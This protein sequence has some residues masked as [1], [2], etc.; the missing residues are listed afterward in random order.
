MIFWKRSSFIDSVRHSAGCN[1]FLL[2]KSPPD[3][4]FQRVSAI[5]G[6]RHFFHTVHS[7]WPSAGNTQEMKWFWKIPAA[8]RPRHEVTETKWEISKSAASDF[9]CLVPLPVQEGKNEAGEDTDLLCSNRNQMSLCPQAQLSSWNRSRA[10]DAGRQDRSIEAA[11]KVEWAACVLIQGLGA[12][13]S[14]ESCWPGSGQGQNWP[15]RGQGKQ[16]SSL[17]HQ[18]LG[19]LSGKSVARTLASDQGG[20][21]PGLW[22]QLLKTKKAGSDSEAAGRHVSGF[23]SIGRFSSWEGWEHM[24]RDLHGRRALDSRQAIASVVGQDSLGILE[25]KES[26][27]GNIL[28]L[29]KVLPRSCLIQILCGCFGLRRVNFEQKGQ[30]LQPAWMKCSQDKS[31]NGLSERAVHWDGSQWVKSRSAQGA[32]ASHRLDSAE[33]WPG[34]ITPSSI[35]I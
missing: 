18:P 25:S 5:E 17:S 11:R 35:S 4:F 20:N 16:A 30:E 13:L 2:F 21:G 24:G 7:F 28:G 10:L 19:Y 1:Y 27:P 33:S 26:S 8:S 14:P 6:S 31:Q 29:C 23:L 12:A 9:G 32:V 34:P 22:S 3:I 15:G